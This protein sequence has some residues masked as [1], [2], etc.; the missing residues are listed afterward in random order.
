MRLA[1]EGLGEQNQRLV[2]PRLTG[3]RRL[4]WHAA[5]AAGGCH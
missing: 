2:A 5:A 4:C 3:D 1:V